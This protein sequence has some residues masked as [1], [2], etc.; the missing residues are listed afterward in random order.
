[1]KQLYD[2]LPED[3]I[4]KDVPLRSFTS[5]RTGGPAD[6]L[7]E[8][9]TDN[10]LLALIDLAQNSSI[11]MLIIGNGS[12]ILISD[13]GFRGM[14]IHLGKR[15]S[16]I[17]VNGFRITAQSGALLSAVA[18]RA[19]DSGLTGF[20]FAA[21]IPGSVGGA[22][23]MNAGAY[24][25]DISQILESAVVLHNG[26]MLSLPAADLKLS[27]RSSIIEKESMVV[28]SAVFSLTVDDKSAVLARM[29]DLNKRR[30]E[31]Q[32]LQFPSC[33]SFFKRP[34]GY[35]AGALIEQAGLKGYSVGDAQVSEKHA[36]FI[37]NRGNAT[38]ADIY[39][40]M[41]HIQDT[42]QQRFGVLLEPEVKLIGDFIS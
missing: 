25:G 10:Q 8:P 1:M 6:W 37:I 34:A 9:E 2:I 38:S 5:M 39:A 36:G 42:V 20:E 32:P 33:G 21:G 7:L 31:K 23:C 35:F 12:N 11:P 16:R 40:L 3:C 19:A 30:R 22:L 14:V 13:L 4:L 27:Y 41:R 17:D 28:L 18:R 15:M 29:E 26:Q 24:G